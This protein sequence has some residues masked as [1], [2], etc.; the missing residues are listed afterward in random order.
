[1]SLVS[2]LLQ[3]APERRTT[4]DKLAADPWVT[5]PVDLTR[6]SWD[7]V[8]RLHRPGGHCL[9]GLLWDGCSASHGHR[10]RPAVAH[11]R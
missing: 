5:Q 6:Y 4:L 3:P 7:E 11:P 9:R 8:C 2:G 10:H 1:M